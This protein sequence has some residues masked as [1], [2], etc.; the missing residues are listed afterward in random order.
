MSDRQS[1]PYITETQAVRAHAVL[2]DQGELARYVARH[3]EDEWLFG[4]P[5]FLDALNDAFRRVPLGRLL[6]LDT[7]LAPTLDLPVG[8]HAWRETPTA[9]WQRTS[10]P[11]GP[12]FFLAYQVRPTAARADGGRVAGA[13]VNCWIRCRSRFVARRLARRTIAGDGWV[14]VQKISEAEVDPS[15]LG[16]GAVPYYNQ[17]QIDGLVLVNHIYPPE[18]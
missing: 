18:P 13:Y 4:G 6:A 8:W 15:A 12:T 17:A 2:L 1:E 16:E 9:P 11:V 14:I 3:A 5:G 7:T 10:L